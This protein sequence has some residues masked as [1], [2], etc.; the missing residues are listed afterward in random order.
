MAMQMPIHIT[1]PLLGRIV[2]GIIGCLALYIALFMYKTERDRWQNRLESIWIGIDKRA[3]QTNSVFTALVNRVSQGTFKVFNNMFGHDTVSW[4][5][6]A[7]SINSSLL[8][9]TTISL[10]SLLGDWNDIAILKEADLYFELLFILCVPLAIRSE[11][12]AVYGGCLIPPVA[13]IAYNF[14]STYLLKESS[15]DIGFRVLM[16]EQMLHVLMLCLSCIVDVL[17]VVVIKKKFGK[18]QFASSGARVFGGISVLLLVAICTCVLPWQVSNRLQSVDG[19]PS[20]IIGNASSYIADLDIT[21]LLY[22]L[23]PSL[24]LVGLVIH[25]VLWPLVARITYPLLDFRIIQERRILI[26]LGT[27]ALGYALG[28]DNVVL[29]IIAALGR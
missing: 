2:T 28:G 11:T 3:K 27:T 14:Y 22:C 23:V 16:S 15:N 19:I 4:K 24:V 21:T 9:A 1:L 18:L 5:L 17:A 6:V 13:N 10:Y 26:P 25:R 20:I 29:K 12:K 7:V 8:M